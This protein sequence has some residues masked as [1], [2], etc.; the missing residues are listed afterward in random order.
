MHAGC[1]FL[2]VGVVWVARWLVRWLVA[3]QVF[4]GKVAMQL[5]RS[6]SPATLFVS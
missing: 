4:V 6:P 3:V 2:L 5:R 1:S